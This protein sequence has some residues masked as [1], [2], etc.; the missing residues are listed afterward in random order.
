[1]AQRRLGEETRRCA[2]CL[3]TIASTR[4][5]M[6][7]GALLVLVTYR[8]RYQPPWL[9]QSY[10]TQIALSPLR[11]ED[12]RT[13]VQSVLQTASVPEAMVQEI[14][15]HAEGNPFFLEEL[16][17]NV[18]EHEGGPPVPQA[19]P[20][21]IEAVL[22]ARVHRLTAPEDLRVRHDAV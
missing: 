1:M 14:V 16:A 12:S 20:D 17:W 4:S 9:A 21:T 22:A 11:A 15:T 13:V 5:A 3:A 8:P 6:N 7:C 2:M 10:A 18:I 19:V